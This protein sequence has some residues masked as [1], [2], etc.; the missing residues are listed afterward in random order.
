[1]TIHIKSEGIRIMKQLLSIFI[2]IVMTLA[3]CSTEPS[4]SSVITAIA[5]TQS[6]KPIKTTEPTDTPLPTATNTLEPTATPK[7]PDLAKFSDIYKVCP[8]SSAVKL[9]AGLKFGILSD[10][11]NECYGKV[12]TDVSKEEGLLSHL[13]IIYKI[14]DGT[15]MP[16]RDAV[17]DQ[18]VEIYIYPSPENL[19]LLGIVLTPTPVSWTLVRA[20]D[21]LP[22][23]YSKSVT[24][25]TRD[26]YLQ[27]V[28]ALP[29]EIQVWIAG[30]GWGLEDM[31]LDKNELALLEA[32][33]E[34]NTPSAMSIITNPSFL[35]GVLLSEVIWAQGYEVESLSELI[36]DDI[37]ELL[38]GGLLSDN[39]RE[40]IQS[41]LILA[42]ENYEISKGIFLIANMGHPDQNKLHYK[43][44]TFNT[45]L[46][47]L[48]KLIDSGIPQGYEV[49]ALAISLD[50]G[51]LYSIAGDDVARK[52]IDYAQAM[53]AFVAETDQILIQENFIDWQAKNYSLEM[54]IELVWG[55]PGK[56]YPWSKEQGWWDA[57]YQ[58]SQRPM[59]SWEFDWLFTDISTLNSMRNWVLE[60]GFLDLRIEQ[61]PAIDNDYLDYQTSYPD[62]YDQTIDRFMANLADYFYIGNLSLDQSFNNAHFDYQF[63]EKVIDVDEKP[64]NNRDIANP[65]WQWDT[66]QESGHLIGTCGDNAYMEAIIAR[67]VNVSTNVM[68]RINLDEIQHIIPI[69]LNPVDKVWR[70]SIYD[71]VRLELFE[72]SN[73]IA[74]F[75]YSSSQIPLSSDSVSERVFFGLIADSF[76]YSVQRRGIPQ[77]YIFRRSPTL[78][79]PG[80]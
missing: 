58:F 51:N 2:L 9:E 62:N 68:A 33:A 32:L 56:F 57:W 26:Q 52:F 79:Q 27:L 80:T 75:H 50:Y 39:G 69:Y 12:S 47:M 64:I 63:E 13:K 73:V 15:T 40:G 65:D 17:I 22:E 14:F 20:I 23:V 55:A 36:Q 4:N 31:E 76:D 34:K 41:L 6:A 48:G 29:K 74:P 49:I 21:N 77:G 43:V 24:V 61:D 67:S 53:M 60:T 28:S 18:E 70:S 19:A 45:Q 5:K 44:P 66:F 72:D 8:S 11:A 78:K 16:E 7:P 59:Q 10:A 46:F 1:M 37:D 71:S 35:D 38:A 3:A 54:A 25:E 30:M 42:E